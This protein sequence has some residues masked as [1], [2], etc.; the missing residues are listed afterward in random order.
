MEC[1]VTNLSKL[2]KGKPAL[3]D[4]SATFPEGKI[5]VI[6][7]PSGSGKTTL[8][9]CIAGLETADVG[10]IMLGGRAVFDSA[11][12]VNV[13]PHKRDI[14]MVF[15]SYGLWPHL[16]VAGNIGFPL[17]IKNMGSAQIATKVRWAL[18]MV[19]MPS[20]GDRM[21]GELSGGEQ[22]RVALARA[23]AS[24]P[25]VLLMDEPLSNLD[26]LLR[27]SVRVEL[28]ELQR[29]LGI[30]MIYI[31][32]DQ[33][34]ALALADQLIVMT[35]AAIAQRGDPKAVYERPSDAFVAGFLGAANL[36]PA[37]I[38]SRQGDT[39][40][41]GGGAML[42]PAR[43]S[44]SNLPAS[45]DDALLMIRPEDLVVTNDPDAALWSG[46]VRQQLFQGDRYIYI[47]DL[48]GGVRVHLVTANATVLEEGSEVNLARRSDAVGLVL[49]AE[50]TRE[51][52]AGS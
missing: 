29:R 6:L 37:R 4:V 51:T 19:G 30:T 31:T 24:E 48:G 43:V 7:G 26:A 34:E 25:G 21:P 39:V 47:I 52:V 28:K 12:S 33:S 11:K 27:E 16:T 8:L 17:K 13:P 10:N 5:T 20:Y 1:T 18:E 3:N 35:K 22:Q 38:L 36:V 46:R 2:F 50:A 9:R 45:G 44:A 14:G 23:F 41:I 42:R 32:H 40:E 49:A 15:Q